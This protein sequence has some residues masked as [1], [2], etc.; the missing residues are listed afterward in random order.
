[1]PRERM[2]SALEWASDVL[3]LT[4]A[5]DALARATSDDLGGRLALD[6]AVVGGAI[7]L[8]LVL[9]ATTLRRRTT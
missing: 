4:Y 3:P 2:A 1:V 9:G 5:Y 8:A 7:V 6:A